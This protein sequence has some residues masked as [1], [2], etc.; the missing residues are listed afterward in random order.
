MSIP[1]V[2]AR[3]TLQVTTLSASFLT[4]IFDETAVISTAEETSRWRDPP[5]EIQQM[6]ISQERE[7][8]VSRD[9]D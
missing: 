7:F 8:G 4:L 6:Q 3:L 9:R 5:F 2:N 1:L